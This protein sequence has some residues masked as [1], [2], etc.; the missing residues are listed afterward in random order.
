MYG[1]LRS[2]K[3]WPRYNYLK[4]W[5][6][7]VQFFFNIEIIAFKVVQIK[8]LAMLL[9]AYDWFCGPG[10]H[11]NSQHYCFYCQILIQIFSIVK[12]RIWDGFGNELILILLVP[13]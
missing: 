5:N 7:R 11:I 2:D 6:L 8:S 9:T 10:S 13:P 4:I 3:I 12:M 1:L